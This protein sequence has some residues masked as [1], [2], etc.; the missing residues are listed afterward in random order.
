MTLEPVS[1]PSVQTRAEQRGCIA[2]VLPV[3]VGAMVLIVTTVTQLVGWSLEQS[4]YEGSL[5]VPDYRWAVALGYSVL[6]LL[7][8]ALLYGFTRS[9]SA[10]A[11]YCAWLAAAGAGLLCVPA[12]LVGLV[13]NL[14][15]AAL[16]LLALVVFLLGL[17]IWL[18]RTGALSSAG[19]GSLFAA[20]FWALVLA[21]PWVL[22]GALGSPLDTLLN[23][24]VGLLTGVA[25][26]WVLHGILLGSD[27]AGTLGNRG[28]ML[29]T[30][31]VFMVTLAILATGIGLNGT[32]W[33]LVIVLMPLAWAA[34]GLARFGRREAR[35]TWPAAA[36][37]LG[38]TAAWPQIFIDPDEMAL[39]VSIGPGELS[40]WATRMTWTTFYTG[41]AASVVMILL[42]NRSAETRR[43]RIAA[44]GL[45]VLA[46]AAA[47]VVYSAAGQP[48]F[49]GERL[50]V[51]LRDQADVSDVA[52]ID[53]Y[54]ARRAA[55]FER[56][57]EQASRTQA[58]LR[59][60]LDRFGL[61]YTPY[62]LINGIEISGGPLLR[63][64]LENRPEVDRVLDSPRMRPLPQVLPFA[65]GDSPAPS[66]PQW[67]L[68]SI[69]APRVWQELGV[70]GEG[71]IVGQS[72]SGVQGDH[73]ELAGSY[74]GAGGS[75][76]YN[77]FDP[78][79]ASRAPQ[80]FG[81]HGT[82]TLA[83]VLGS[84][85]GV[86]PGAAWIG[87]TNMGRNLGNPALYLDCMQFM[88]APFPYG[89]D[90]FVDGDPARGAMVLNNSWG[91]PD[92]EGCDNTSLQPA[93]SALRAAG[94]F[95]VV[96]AG[97]S[98]YS[99]CGS[100]SDPPAIYDE[101]YSVG[102]LDSNGD[103]A[104]FSSL[105]P[106][107]VDGS[108]RMKPDIAA[109]GLGVLSAYPDSTYQITSGTSMAGPHVV[110]VVALMWS[111]NPALIG[112]ID[113][114]TEILN[115]TA[116]PYTGALPEC[117]DR[118]ARP[119]AGAGYGMLDAYAAVQAALEVAP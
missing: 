7:P 11:A 69:G 1:P 19:S 109:P 40:G 10:R 2:A 80:D 115:Q 46:L 102:A 59:A 58:G 99:G 90:P 116:A 96:S 29:N 3:L 94:L 89:G 5:G 81:G 68:T 60:D 14:A 93:V 86:A 82:H 72:D 26:S 77:W 13:D 114:T 79:Y 31:L 88:L 95:V 71:V 97:N 35:S 32:Q 73:P 113:L 75:H 91:C 22:W 39:V 64:W 17:G 16:Q 106:V 52:G 21:V 4:L 54:S 45:A 112:D 98:G 51:V 85:V 84:T 83:S 50:F 20:L 66:E 57:V 108:Q 8:L 41:V 25:A 76:D 92:R 107:V 27:E 47:A 37:L 110:G 104:E 61:E 28:R 6:L 36:L 101:V 62:Y 56:L 44:A 117:V 30:G 23:L 43:T 9:G 24:L 111:A 49:Y 55:V 118:N 65:R 100:V 18:R 15:V 67:N 74:R 119:N 48:G 103:L 63:A 70:N 78:W 33:M 53:E 34:V 42:S 105:G 12:R 38:L 87:C